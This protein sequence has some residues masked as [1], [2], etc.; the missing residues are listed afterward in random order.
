MG[1][2]RPP[3][4]EGDPAPRLAAPM[5]PGGPK[6]AFT[7]PDPAKSLGELRPVEVPDMGWEV[8]M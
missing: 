3:S 6:G 7:V 8:G 2:N 5:D 1:Y 4:S